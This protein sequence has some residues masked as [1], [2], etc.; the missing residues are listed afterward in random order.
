MRLVHT[1]RI[2]FICNLKNIFSQETNKSTVKYL[3]IFSD[4]CDQEVDKVMKYLYANSKLEL[5]RI[6]NL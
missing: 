6:N 2:Y 3:I 4:D 5:I 1:K